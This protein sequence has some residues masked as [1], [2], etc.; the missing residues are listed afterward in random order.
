MCAGMTEYSMVS[1]LCIVRP[2]RGTNQILLFFMMGK[3][4]VPV[5][6]AR[7]TGLS[8]KYTEEEGG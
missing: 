6:L 8:G 2:D 7:T 4:S 3:A 1:V 5:P